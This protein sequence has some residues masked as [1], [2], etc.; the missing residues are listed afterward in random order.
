MDFLRA[1][2]FVFGKAWGT[3]PWIHPW[4]GSKCTAPAKK[5]HGFLSRKSNI[6]CMDAAQCLKTE[7]FQSFQQLTIFVA[8]F[9]GVKAL[10]IKLCE[11]AVRNLQVCFLQ[12]KCKWV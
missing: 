5:D 2:V 4:F 7:V 3:G 11:E 1:K 9:C 8:A 12:L 10:Y 6:K